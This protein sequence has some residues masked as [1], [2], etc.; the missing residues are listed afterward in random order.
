MMGGGFAR[1]PA[2]GG[3]GPGMMHDAVADTLGM[4]SQELWTAAP[5]AHASRR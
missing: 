2:A 4:T 3:F 1:G 5:F